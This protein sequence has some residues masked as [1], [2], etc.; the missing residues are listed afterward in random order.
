[1][2]VVFSLIVLIFFCLSAFPGLS[3]NGIQK[4]K[5]TIN[6]KADSI[7]VKQIDSISNYS[8][9]I[10]GKS[11]SVSINNDNST[12]KTLV[13]ESKKTSANAIEI[14]GEGNSVTINQNGK[15]S[16]VNVQQN[17]NGNKVNVSQ[18]KPD[19]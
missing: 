17:G 4:R 16:H 19:K 7:A 18:S 3:E 14:N 13:T 15:G 6:P 11:N 9:N 10:N 8:I 2:K 5:A 12:D 1:M